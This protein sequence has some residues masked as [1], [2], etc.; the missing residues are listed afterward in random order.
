MRDFTRRPL[1]QNK[2]SNQLHGRALLRQRRGRAGDAAPT[3][4]AEMTRSRRGLDELEGGE[5]VPDGSGCCHRRRGLPELGRTSRLRHTTNLE[6]P[7]PLAPDP[8]A[9]C[10]AGDGD[11]AW[12]GRATG[13]T[14]CCS[15][16][17]LGTRAPR[18]PAAAEMRMTRPASACA[19]LWRRATRW[20]AGASPS[21]SRSPPPGRRAAR[22]RRGLPG[23]T[24]SGG[25]TSSARSPGARRRRRGWRGRP[26]AC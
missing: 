11:G 12:P 2:K 8:S 20:T 14:S 17:L 22:R 19:G 16:C 3:T 6:I 15:C 7:S 24:A 9:C 26:A 4:R 23:R 25:R 21:C 5:A 1:R 18:P 10:A 13:T